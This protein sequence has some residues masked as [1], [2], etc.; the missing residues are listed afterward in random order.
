MSGPKQEGREWENQETQKNMEIHF[1]TTYTAQHNQRLTIDHTS[2]HHLHEAAIWARVILC[3]S[4]SGLP[5]LGHSFKG[6]VSTFQSPRY[7]G[8]VQVTSSSPEVQD[9]LCL[10]SLKAWYRQNS[11]QGSHNKKRGATKGYYKHGW[12]G[13][14]ILALVKEGKE[15]S[16]LQLKPIPVFLTCQSR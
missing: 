1:L 8:L 15:F 13:L 5:L 6:N 11:T 12:E 7:T 3:L 2:A 16:F 4:G 14:T 9:L 10:A